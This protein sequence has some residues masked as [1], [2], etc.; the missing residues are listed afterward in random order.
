M[1]RARALAVC[2]V[3]VAGLAAHAGG[4]DKLVYQDNG[5]DAI[6]VIFLGC[7]ST[8][9]RD[10]LGADCTAKAGA[11]RFIA[12]VS[13]PGAAGLNKEPLG[14][15]ITFFGDASML[16][17]AAGMMLDAYA[18]KD[19]PEN[20]KIIKAAA[21]KAAAAQTQAQRDAANKATL[22]GLSGAW[23]AP[24]GDRFYLY[25][26]RL[27]D[28]LNGRGE[29]QAS[30]TLLDSSCGYGTVAT[31]SLWADFGSEQPRTPCWEIEA[32]SANSL[33]LRLDAQ[34]VRVYARSAN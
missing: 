5:R 24:G 18:V 16:S 26:G 19:T 9:S 11:H 34:T 17:F 3:C 13:D 21:A 29:I 33:T 2:G 8:G 12:I 14:L 15:E 30:M 25:N 7:E 20:A 22:N 31:Q 10:A 27:T 6:D 28:P 23:A 1:K 4:H 32:M